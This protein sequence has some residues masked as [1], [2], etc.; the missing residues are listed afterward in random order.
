VPLSQSAR[1]ALEAAI[2]LNPDG[3]RALL[4]SLRVAPSAVRYI[5]RDRFGP[6]AHMV[7]DAER[8]GLPPTARRR[9][10]RPA[11]PVELHGRAETFQQ[12]WLA[13][14]FTKAELADAVEQCLRQAGEE[15][16]TYSGGWRAVA[17][18]PDSGTDPLGRVFPGQTR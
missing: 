17:G 12:E 1:E 6:L 9:F 18:G 16:P 10:K 15:V 11:L 8:P 2:Q 7:V 4:T 5:D 3:A 14:S 13:R